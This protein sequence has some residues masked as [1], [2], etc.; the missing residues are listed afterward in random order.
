MSPPIKIRDGQDIDREEVKTPS[1][2]IRKRKQ[3]EGASDTSSFSGVLDTRDEQAI[4]YQGVE[5]NTNVVRRIKG[6]EMID[7][8][9]GITDYDAT[10]A[11]NEAF[12]GTFMNIDKDYEDEKNDAYAVKVIK[13]TLRPKFATKVVDPET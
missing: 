11:F 9:K 8:M 1:D 6:Y 5:I 7:T 4:K 13:N 3:Q 10:R 2:I 12:E